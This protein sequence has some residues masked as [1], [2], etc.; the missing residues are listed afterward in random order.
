MRYCLNLRNRSFFGDLRIICRGIKSVLHIIPK[1]FLF[2]LFDSIIPTI[3][4]YFSLYMSAKL[5]NDLTEREGLSK[6]F[7]LVTLTLLV[8]FFVSFIRRIIT[9]HLNIERKIADQRVLLEISRITNSLYYSYIESPDIK[10]FFNNIS[11]NEINGRGHTALV[12]YLIHFISALIQIFASIALTI[13]MFFIASEGYF[14]GFLAFIN[15]Y[16]ASAIIILVILLSTVANFLLIYLKNSEINKIRNSNTDIWQKYKY[17]ANINVGVGAAEIRIYDESDM[18]L[19]EIEKSIY[20]RACDVDVPKIESK[21][22]MINNVIKTVMQ[23]IIYIYISAKTFIGV[24]GVGNFVLYSGTV[25]KFVSGA[26]QLVNNFGNIR[27][28]IAPHLELFFKYSD[29]PTHN[30]DGK[31]IRNKN[32]SD[33]CIEYKNLSFKYPGTEN[34][35]LKNINIRIEPHQKIALVGMNGSGKTTFVKLLCRLYNPTN[36]TITLNEQEIENYKYDDYYK[37]LSVVFQDFKLFEFTIGEN[38]SILENYD[39][40]IVENIIKK[41]RLFDEYEISGDILD[42]P[43]GREFNE[44]GILFSGGE[45]QKIAIARALYKDAPFIILD[46]PTSALDPLAEADIFLRLNEIVGDKTTIFISH[47]LFSCKFCDKI[48]VFDKGQIIQFGSHDELLSDK[49]GKYYELW[50]AQSQYYK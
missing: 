4:S 19:K 36:G 18:M 14:K 7:V 21:Y 26:V 16:Y 40:N 8:N 37:C 47:R 48:I 15:S 3:S 44:T 49:Y 20:R 6:I 9:K 31:T 42:A 1:Y 22:N 32:V 34:Y 29:L 10:D 50:H 33:F 12:D 28:V 25:D 11:H 30:N 39:K 46:E 27:I 41:I 2:S 23:L 43:V 38:I 13:K 5:I 35:V 17:Y 45:S 24:F